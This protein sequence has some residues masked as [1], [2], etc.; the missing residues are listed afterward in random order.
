VLCR[1]FA[2]EWNKDSSELYI[3]GRFNLMN[4]GT[5]TS[6]I[7]LWTLANGIVPFEGGGVGLSSPGATDGEVE[8]LVY[9]EESHV[10]LRGN[11][12]DIYFIYC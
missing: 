1:V 7:C 8:K 12:T 9:H 6:G 4:G 11:S 5:I 10:R 2:L 3:A